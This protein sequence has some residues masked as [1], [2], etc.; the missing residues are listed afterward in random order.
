MLSQSGCVTGTT[1]NGT[2]EQHHDSWWI[3]PDINLNISSLQ[4]ASGV[5]TPLHKHLTSSSSAGNL[6]CICAG[7]LQLLHAGLFAKSPQMDSVLLMSVQCASNRSTHRCQF[8]DYWW[9][10]NRQLWIVGQCCLIICWPP[11]HVLCTYIY[12][13]L[14]KWRTLNACIFPVVYCHLLTNM[15]HRYF[16]CMYSIFRDKFNQLGF[17]ASLSYQA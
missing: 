17:K 3:H 8:C 9:L 12:W 1:P 4:S 6:K 5:L 10:M 2:W 7:N 14:M 11:S 13:L 15:H 16:S